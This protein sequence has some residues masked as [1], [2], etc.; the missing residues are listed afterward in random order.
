MK[1]LMHRLIYEEE[2]QGMMEYALI[3]ALV[4][5]A[6]VV[7]IAAFGDKIIA[8]FTKGDKKITEETGQ[9]LEDHDEYEAPTHSG[10]E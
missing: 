3:I 2:A 4:A 5:V 7:V 6:A 10:L 1:E 8:I 9:Q